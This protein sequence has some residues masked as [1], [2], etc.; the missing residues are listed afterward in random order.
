[1]LHRC[2][3]QFSTDL[4]LLSWSFAKTITDQVYIT[5]SGFFSNPPF[6][7]ALQTF[8]IDRL[9]FSVDYPYAINEDGRSFGQCSRSRRR[10]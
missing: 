6:V 9:I 3:H 5:S 10:V 4:S 7:A 2:D 1:M 8:G